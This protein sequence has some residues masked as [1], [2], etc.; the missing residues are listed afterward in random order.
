M[1]TYTLYTLARIYSLYPCKMRVR[2]MIMKGKWN[3]I[4]Y[5]PLKSTIICALIIN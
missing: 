5:K 4:A 1:P 2:L 3:V